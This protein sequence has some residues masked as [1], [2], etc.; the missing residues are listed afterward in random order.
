V[1]SVS[2]IAS[3]IIEQRA[4]AEGKPA[5]TYRFAGDRAVLVEYGEMEFADA[6][7]LRPAVDD[8]LRGRP[9]ERLVE[10]APGFRSILLSY[11]P[12]VLA[13]RSFS[14]ISRSCTASGIGAATSMFSTS[15]ASTA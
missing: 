4:A 15:C 13:T 12:L 5:V 6:E 1:G 2:A 3:A 8:A 14:T 7:L 10:T 9:L 11:D